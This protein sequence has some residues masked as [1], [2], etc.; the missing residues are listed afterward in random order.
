MEDM[1]LGCEKG[2]EYKKYKFDV[3]I[4]VTVHENVNCQF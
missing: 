3:N 2:G 1:L 4:S